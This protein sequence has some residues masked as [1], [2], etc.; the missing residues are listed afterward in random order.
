MDALVANLRVAM[1]HR[2]DNN[3]WMSPETKAKADEKL[4][5]FMVK[6][7]YPE[8]WRD[9][10]S[11]QLKPDDAVGNT[12]AIA[13]YNWAYDRGRLTR[14]TDRGE[15]GMTPQLVN[16]SYSSTK[17]A[18]T[19]PAAI[20]QPPFFDP[21]ADPAVNYGG[22]G[23]VIGHEISHGFDDQGRKAN[24]DG[25]LTD[26]WTP[27]DAARFKAEADRFGAQYDTYEPVPGA[28]VQGQLTMG[29]NIGDLA[30]LQMAL[31]AYHMSLD[32]KPAPVID[33]LTG[34]QRVFLGWAQVWREK[35]REASA[36]QQVVSDP[37]APA[38]FRVIGPARN[39]DAWYTAFDVK[40]GE[41]YYLAPKDR[42]RIW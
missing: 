19:F 27:Q 17:N 2:I 42:V 6:I 26:W 22:I 15:W 14:P 37:H 11:I 13:R 4:S 39:I 41:K 18:I 8:T 30:G 40:P 24:G 35:R 32:G 36:R 10:S 25:V 9:Y 33:G 1:K 31:E 20:L 23:G 3:D 12:L 21:D 38:Q 16:A 7:G 5:K 28:H 29:E 34:E